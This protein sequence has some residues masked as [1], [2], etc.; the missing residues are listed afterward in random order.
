MNPLCLHA[1]CTVPDQYPAPAV[2]HAV[3]R[4][5]HPTKSRTR[6]TE[7]NGRSTA[8][9]PACVR[10]GR[11]DPDGRRAGRRRPGRRAWPLARRGWSGLNM[12][13]SMLP[14]GPAFETTKRRKRKT[15]RGDPAAGPA[16]SPHGRGTGGAG[17]RT[18][19]PTPRDGAGGGRG[20][21]GDATPHRRPCAR[22][23]TATG[24]QPRPAISV[25]KMILDD[26]RPSPHCAPRT[27]SHL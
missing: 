15:R 4:A 9:G 5:R 11:A 12:G 24:G 16:S 17:S 23:H 10:R 1:T 26:Q 2:R 25:M 8:N 6:S 27:C 13:S 18:G 22:A 19:R 7:R 14:P 20:A 3:E 21:G